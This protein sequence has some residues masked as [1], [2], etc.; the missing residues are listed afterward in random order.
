MRVAAGA[1]AVAAVASAAPSFSIGTVHSDA[2]PILSS[3]NADS[4]PDSY[5]VKF[6]DHVTNSG[7][8]DHHSWVQDIHAKKGD[9]RLELRKRSQEPLVETVFEGLKHTYSIGGFLGYSGHFDEAT[10]EEV[11]RHPD[12]S[13]YTMQTLSRVEA[14]ANIDRYRSSSSRRTP[15]STPWRL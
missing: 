8:S 4:I 5:I 11:R 10:I 9:Q 15:S 2:A 6:K 14:A 12:V 1:L 7:A 13:S 3:S